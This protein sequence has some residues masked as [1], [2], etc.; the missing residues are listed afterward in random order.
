MPVTRVNP[1]SRSTAAVVLPVWLD[2]KADTV[3]AWVPGRVLAC[4]VC[5]TRDLV[6]G[7]FRRD[8][9]GAPRVAGDAFC[10]RHLPRDWYTE[11]DAIHVSRFGD[12]APRWD[13]SRIRDLGVHVSR[14]SGM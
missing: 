7:E 4:Q 5:R 10:L 12:G 9:A 14:A 13:P 2:A 6:W 1:R 11:H 8:V 3:R